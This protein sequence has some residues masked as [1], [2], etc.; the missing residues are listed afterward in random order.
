MSQLTLQEGKHKGKTLQDI[1]EIDQDY[2]IF[3]A[4]INLKYIQREKYKAFFDRIPEI[5]EA[6]KEMT[7]D[8]VLTNTHA[9]QVRYPGGWRGW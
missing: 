3:L 5:V 9:Q 6:A 2:V 4:Q 7:R 8:V 1:W